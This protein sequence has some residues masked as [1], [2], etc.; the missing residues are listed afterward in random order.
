MKK[1][2]QEFISVFSVSLITPTKAEFTTLEELNRI[3]LT[4]P[5]KNITIHEAIGF[6]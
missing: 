6:G 5:T 4:K 1:Y 2:I 3:R